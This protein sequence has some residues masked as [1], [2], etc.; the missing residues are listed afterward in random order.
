MDSHSDIGRVI[1]EVRQ[2]SRYAISAASSRLDQWL[3]TLVGRA[4]SDLLLVPGAPASIRFEGEVRPIDRETLDGPG[5]EAA[6]V[7]A[8]T[9][10]RAATV[11][12]NANS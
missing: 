6:V 5:I 10:A 1:P 2:R 11:S 7:P 12:R 4:G 9:P 8:L 3:A